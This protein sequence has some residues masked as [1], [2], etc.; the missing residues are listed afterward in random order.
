MNL[1]RRAELR[2]DQRIVVSRHRG[3]K[4]SVKKL[5]SKPT[6]LAV[7]IYISVAFGQI[8][9]GVYQSSHTDPPPPFDFVYRFGL[10]CLMTWW[11]LQDSRKRG[12]T[13]F[14]DL[15]LFIYVAWVVILPYHLIK[16]RRLR[17]ML[18]IFAFVAVFVVASLLGLI[19]SWLIN[20]RAVEQF[21]SVID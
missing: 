10:P 9:T 6:F 20:P 16:T 7:A 12:I 21:L 5:F 11:L 17:A 1:A 19:I 18:P 3:A 13:W 8:A 14:L 2:F 15:G 4:F